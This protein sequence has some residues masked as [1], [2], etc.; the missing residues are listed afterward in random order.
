MQFGAAA[1]LSLCG[2]VGSTPQFGMCDTPTVD[3]ESSAATV[4]SASLVP[5]A[6]GVDVSAVF[7]TQTLSAVKKPGKHL[8]R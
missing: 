5:S 3:R 2:A 8:I 7:R 6:F 1:D 4:G